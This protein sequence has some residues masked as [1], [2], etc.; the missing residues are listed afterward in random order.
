MSFTKGQQYMGGFCGRKEEM[1][2]WVRPK[3]QEWEETIDT[4]GRFAVRYL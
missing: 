2:Q 3:V 4:L 1:E